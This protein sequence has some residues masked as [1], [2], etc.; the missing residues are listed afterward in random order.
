MYRQVASW[1]AWERD[2]ALIPAA[3]ID[4]AVEAGGQPVLMPPFDVGSQGFTAGIEAF[5]G[6]IDGLMLVG[7]GDVNAERH[8]QPLDQRAGHAPGHWGQC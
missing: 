2:A 5:V 6:A 8:G 4:L 1:G 7:G 3:S